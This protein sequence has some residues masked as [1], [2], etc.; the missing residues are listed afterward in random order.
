MSPDEAK[1]HNKKKRV[2][3][4]R[5]SSKRDK[6]LEILDVMYKDGKVPDSVLISQELHNRGYHLSK[7]ILKRELV[8]V[9]NDS[10]FVL[11]L[12]RHNYSSMVEYCFENLML[13]IRECNKLIEQKWT[14]DKIV[15]KSIITDNGET[16]IEEKISTQDTAGPKLRAMNTRNKSIEI[17]LNVL[18]GGVIDVSIALIDKQ[19]QRVQTERD[20]FEQK[21]NAIVPKKV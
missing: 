19:L 15:K 13:T 21:Y 16:I 6:I 3:S 7:K 20:Q 11:D 8:A 18:K 2:P 1:I 10:D 12:A 4:K 5:E 17:M 14:N 9:N